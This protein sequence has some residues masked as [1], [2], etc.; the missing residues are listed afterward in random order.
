MIS[1]DVGH[2]LIQFVYKYEHCLNSHQS[3]HGTICILAVF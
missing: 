1:I 2:T 3:R